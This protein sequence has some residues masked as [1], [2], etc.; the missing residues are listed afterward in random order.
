MF[1]PVPI[2]HV[3]SSQMGFGVCG[4][5]ASGALIVGLAV[6]KSLGSNPLFIA[7]VVVFI[8]GLLWVISTAI[9]A[10][11]AATNSPKTSE[12]SPTPT[13]SSIN[14]KKFVNSPTGAVHGVDINSDDLEN[15]GVIS[16]YPPAPPGSGFVF[17]G[18]HDIS[19]ANIN[20][21]VQGNAIDAAGSERISVSNSN[22]GLQEKWMPQN[23]KD[24]VSASETGEILLDQCPQETGVSV[25][26]PA[27]LSAAIEAWVG[28]TIELLAEWPDYQTLFGNEPA[29]KYFNGTEDV[30]AIVTQ[31]M[32]SRMKTLRSVVRILTK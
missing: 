21:D 3:T 17:R 14:A 5:G 23:V 24:V 16:E 32:T 8:L 6:H 25:Y 20:F 31:Q 22:V 19:I 18:S 7:S 29:F 2:N 27:T 15:S 13:R 12:L 28:E 11:H 26:V 9:H 10:I 1:R 4:V 30:Q